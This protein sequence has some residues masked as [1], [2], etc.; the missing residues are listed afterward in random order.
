VE[1]DE[2]HQTGDLKV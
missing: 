2:P 1:E